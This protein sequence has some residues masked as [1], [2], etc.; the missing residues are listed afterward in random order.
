[1]V[2]LKISDGRCQF[3]HRTAG[4]VK[5]LI[6]GASASI[7]DKCVELCVAA[8][9]T[10]PPAKMQESSNDRHLYQRIASHFAPMPPQELFATSR[11]YP[12]RQQADLQD[13]LNELL[14]ER[15]IPKNFVGIHQ[16]YRHD[17]LGFSKLLERGHNAVEAAPAQYEDVAIGDGETVRCL[18]NGLWLSTDEHGAYA[19]VLAQKNDYHGGGDLVIE[20]AAPPGE[21]GAELCTRI[22]D[23]LELRLSKGSCYRGR[24]LSLEQ[25]YMSSGHAARICV[26]ELE[27][28]SRAD[29]ILPEL[30]LRAVER[31]VL[32]FAE[33]RQALRDLGL[34]TQ[35]G[36]LFHGTPGTGKTHCIRYLAGALTGHTTFLITADGAG[37]LPEYMALARL[38]QPALV[39]IEDADLIARNRSERDNACDEV[40]LNRLLNEMD[41][42][43]ERADVFFILTTNRPETLEPALASRPGRIDQTIEFPLPDETHRR[44]LIKLYAKTLPVPPELMD[45]L[46]GR[47]DLASPAFIKEL[48]RRIAQHHLEVGAD[49]DVSRETAESALHEMLFSGGTLNTRLLGGAGVDVA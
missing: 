49:G 5:Q 25:H 19:I 23:A 18:K 38:L 17:I 47:T 31:N 21:V 35:K 48:L 15:H 12:L 10:S 1:M 43:R 29:V 30:T 14:G 6:A 45:D 22:F 44:R 34:S 27:T 9:R 39:V 2:D 26:H 41:G 28:V 8:L 7:C 42:L 11:T 33:Q 40:M 24:V 4:D 20:I 32:R 16:Q 46:A 3:C 37:L 13:A 36:L